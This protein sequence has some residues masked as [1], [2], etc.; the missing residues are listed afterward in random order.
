MRDL[1]SISYYK[2]GIKVAV[3]YRWQRKGGNMQ[4]QECEYEYGEIDRRKVALAVLALLV[5]VA[6][7]IIA[8]Y[9]FTDKTKAST[10]IGTAAIAPERI[11][12]ISDEISGDILD[13]IRT[14]I[15][16]DM[17]SQSVEKE[18]TA[19]KIYEVITEPGSDVKELAKKEIRS[20][21]IKLLSEQGIGKEKS[22]ADVFTE[23]QKAEIRKMIDQALTGTLASVD[24]NRAL[25]EEEKNSLAKQLRQ[26][27]SSYLQSQIQHS[28]AQLTKQDIEKIK[29]SLQ[30]EKLVQ[31]AAQS[32]T[33]KQIDKL[34][35]N[36]LARLKKSMKSFAKNYLTQAQAK[37]LQEK[38]L[39]KAGKT[40]V[41]KTEELAE[42]I[43]LVKTSVN[44][45]TT[46]IQELK[47]LNDEKTADLST[48]QA[49]IQEI[50]RLIL[51]INSV[52]KELTE[53]IT[54]SN[55][56]L[57][58]VTGNGSKLQSEKVSTT[59]LTVAEFVDVLAGNDQVY[60]GAIQELDKLVD[61]LKEENK[62]QDTAFEKSV[63][64][65]EQSLSKNGEDL[66]QFKAQ[67][68]KRDEEW[69]KQMQQQTQEQ[70]SQ[71]KDQADKQ[72]QL[73]KEEQKERK[74]A[75]NKL[76][77]QVDE[78][79]QLIGDKDS[80]GKI[81]GD[82]IFEK[83][84]SVVKILS[85]DG[86]D[87]LISALKNIG[88]AKT[89]EEGVTNIHT[90][91]TDA[92]TRVGELEKEKW[93]SDITLLAE[94]SAENAG[95]YFYQESGSAY[96]YQIPLVMEQ[97]KINLDESDTVIVIDFKRP[98]KLPSN[99][100]FSTNGNNL[101]ITFTNKPTRNIEILSIHVYK[102]K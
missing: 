36:I 2:F 34:T 18:L 57:E 93:Y 59:N 10:G 23:K 45:L 81:E 58:K 92:R 47:A 27:L 89:L 66:E 87:G 69:N 60:T 67:Q 55:K 61:Q 75:D 3:K 35:D 22:S 31:T 33:H 30:I 41:E 15:L 90:D 43:K 24:V 21:V 64:E 83:I 11:K 63:K 20:V 9:L 96:V 73:L 86:L 4:Q 77:S 8:I 46:R 42:K 74:D 50:N 13:T 53:S 51:E 17:V 32:A 98:D 28:T 54:V 26:Q 80:A 94:A 29:N 38:I 102:Q 82:T 100:A 97:D 40:L 39:K 65:L 88:G 19:E 7:I 99:A 79:N 37:K 56:N 68:E 72:E 78:T 44:E 71:L 95:S 12:Q 76:Q 25:S 52:T 84:G 101:L 91:L 16:A 70:G 48:M 85:T 5:I 1:K 6:A 49:D 14:E 62:N